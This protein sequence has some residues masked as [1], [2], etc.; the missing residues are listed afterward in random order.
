MENQN[1]GVFNVGVFF[2][3]ATKFLMK[4]GVK[5]VTQEQLAVA[6]G[7]SQAYIAKLVSGRGSG[8]E[9]TRRKIAAALGFDGAEEGK[10]YQDY[11]DIGREVQELST[12]EKGREPTETPLVEVYLKK[13]IRESVN[14]RL[15]E[16]EENNYG[17][18][19]IVAGVVSTVY[20][21]LFSKGQP[22][23]EVLSSLQPLM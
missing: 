14:Q 5:K 18:F 22:T 9:A 21:S 13:A 19:L 7:L 17:L 4:H 20:K 6:T 2:Q 3:T 23:E 16:I 12:S 1:E 8:T 11:L 10:S 15:N